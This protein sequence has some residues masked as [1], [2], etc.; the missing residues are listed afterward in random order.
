MKARWYQTEAL[1]ALFEFLKTHRGYDPSSGLPVAENPLVAL[2]TGTGKAFV[3]AKFI[4]TAI[5]MVPGTRIINA[6][7]TKELVDQNAKELLGIWPSAPV[8][9]YSAGLRRK[10]TMQPITFGGIASLIGAV[11]RFGHID[12]LLV[13]EAHMISPEGATMYK[14]FIN[15]LQKVNPYLRVVGFTATPFRMKQGLLTEDGLF[16]HIVYDMTGLQNFNRLIAEGFLAPLISR[17]TKTELDVS[18]VGMVNGEYNKGEL[19]K[20]VDKD[21][22][23]HAALTEVCELGW[24]RR[25]WLIFASGKEHSEHCA[26]KLRSFGVTAEAVH[27][28]LKA[29]ERDK[30]IKAFKN[31][32]LRAIVN[33]NILTT[34]FNHP[35]LDLIAMLRP[36]MSTG[37]WVQMLGRG[38]RPCS[39]KANC[40]VLDFAGNTK[41]LGPIN[42]PVI[43]KRRKPGEAGE[44]PVKVCGMCGCYNHTRAVTCEVCGAAFEFET[45]ITETSSTAAL[46]K[47][48]LPETDWFRVERVLY[49]Q[50]AKPGK[51]PTMRVV[52]HSGLNQFSEF[53][54]FE[55]DGFAGKRA[56][57]WWRSR[58]GA[59]I[60]PPATV[61]EALQ[62]KDEL[63]IPKYVRV[64]VNKSPYPEVLSY[65]FTGVLENA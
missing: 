34:G 27:S 19:E 9:I 59:D 14:R 26:E 29:N 53:V 39:G 46:L 4:E 32:D 65:N 51:L 64:W 42:D 22:I 2:P 40:L 44:M 48:D 16:T 57:D 55:H 37:L 38:T 63:T 33:N 21:E 35:P 45:K 20:A 25:S 43:P 3:I 41:R 62:R 28:G 8:G 1:D 61:F 52:Y 50:H 54:C 11:E 18:S 15:E 7:H 24:Q 6:I 5:Q 12:L 30:R 31:D 13:D 23:T 36:T 60:V 10:D 47:S 49:A 17:P 56:R 58:A